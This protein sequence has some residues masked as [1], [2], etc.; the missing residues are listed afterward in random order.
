M[1][2]FTW[3]GSAT[4]HY[5]LYKEPIRALCSHPG[6]QVRRWAERMLRRL[7]DQI[8]DARDDDDEWGARWDIS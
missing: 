8:K 2:S 5:G 6:R 1:N 7:D 3:S 4:S